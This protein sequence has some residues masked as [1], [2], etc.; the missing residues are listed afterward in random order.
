MVS[1]AV[2]HLQQALRIHPNY[3]NAYLLLGNA[4]NYL[5]EYDRSI[6]AYKGALSIDPNQ[7]RPGAIWG[8]LM[9]RR[10]ILW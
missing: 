10:K 7:K 5:Q 3:K 4:Y 8:L 1:Q 9:G 6:E 2:E